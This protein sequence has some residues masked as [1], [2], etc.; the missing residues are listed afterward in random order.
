M[1]RFIEH[2]NSTVAETQREPRAAGH[3]RLYVLG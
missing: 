1:P 3:L 2:E